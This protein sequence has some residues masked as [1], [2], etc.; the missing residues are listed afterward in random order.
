MIRLTTTTS[1][2][3]ARPAAAD[4]GDSDTIGR[5]RS[6]TRT[7]GRRTGGPRGFTLVELL[8]VI[9]VLAILTAL[10]LPAINAALRTARNAAVSAEIN[11]LASALESFKCQVRR[12]SAEPG[13][14]GGE[15][16]LHDY[17][18]SNAVAQLID[19]EFA[20]HGRHHGGPARAR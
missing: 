6:D 13:P 5:C 19:V 10:L 11:Q 3:H 9:V 20:G 2:R 16:E 8:V 17:I 12:L 14:A 7:D 4:A 15:W 18:G 1:E